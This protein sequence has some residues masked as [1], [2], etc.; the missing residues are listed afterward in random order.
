MEVRKQNQF[1]LSSIYDK[2]SE[3]KRNKYELDHGHQLIQYERKTIKSGVVSGNE[4]NK[5]VKS[6]KFFN[7]N[8]NK[9]DDVENIRKKLMEVE[10]TDSDDSDKS[11]IKSD[12]MS[13]NKSK[14]NHQINHINRKTEKLSKSLTQ[15]HNNSRYIHV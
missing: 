8:Q 15:N 1:G 2:K 9:N 11:Q 7:L 10:G 5:S 13:E 6:K 12:K 14:I 4:N 3:L